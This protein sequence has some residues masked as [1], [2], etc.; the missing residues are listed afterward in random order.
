MSKPPSWK[1]HEVD[2]LMNLVGKMPPA[3]IAARIGRSKRAVISYCYRRRVSLAVS[4][5]LA[6]WTD[7]EITFL[8]KNAEKMTQA[9]MAE[10]LGRTRGS[11][12]Q[13]CYK[14]GISTQ[15]YGESHHSARYSDE[16]V[17][18]C[19]QLFD[20]GVSRKE[21]CEKME[22]SYDTVVDILL[23]RFRTHFPSNR[24]EKCK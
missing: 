5:I 2:Q 6:P 19:R 14:L 20:A 23:Y 24:K 22:I 3:E 11:V 18:L 17:E 7:K 10:A 12:E 13:K 8:R 15:R 16:D 21:I 4:R 1:P 9:Q